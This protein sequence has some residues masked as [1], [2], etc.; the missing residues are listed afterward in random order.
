MHVPQD[1]LRQYLLARLDEN[2]TRE[3]NSHLADCAACVEKLAAGAA[4]SECASKLVFERL[5]QERTSGGS[6]S[7]QAL[8]PFS[9]QQCEAWLIDVSRTATKV[10]VDSEI[11]PGT[12]VRLRFKELILFG[13][14]QYYDFVG[15]RY[16]LS[17]K[18]I[19][20]TQAF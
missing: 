9:A 5:E 18:I 19:S 12:L 7:L 17:M 6:G 15:N 2:R 11:D 1:E 3:V 14:V 13:A 10:M 20:A 16:Y 4:S 8:N